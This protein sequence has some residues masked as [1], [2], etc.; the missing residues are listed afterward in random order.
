MRND[1]KSSFDDSSWLLAENPT[2]CLAE[3]DG[4]LQT[5]GWDVSVDQVD[6]SEIFASNGSE[7]VRF[8]RES[9]EGIF[10]MAN[11]TPS[12]RLDVSTRR[13]EWELIFV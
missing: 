11:G 10:L 3:V 12:D 9:R 4:E 1:R 6:D 7:Q 8:C 5:R 13:T 2:A